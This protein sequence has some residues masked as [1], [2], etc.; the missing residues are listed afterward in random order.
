MAR[1]ESLTKLKLVLESGTSLDV[2]TDGD[3]DSA[4]D[5]WE[6]AMED[7]DDMLVRFANGAFDAGCIAGIYLES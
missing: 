4:V 3:L 5:A 7:D 1:K 6:E 2:Y